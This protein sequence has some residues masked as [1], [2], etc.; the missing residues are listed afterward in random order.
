M[1]TENHFTLKDNF[2]DRKSNFLSKNVYYLLILFFINP[3]FSIG[4]STFLLIKQKGKYDYQ[5]KTLYILISA[6]LG[7]IMTTKVPVSDLLNMKNQFAIAGSMDFFKYIFSFGKEPVFYAFS[8]IFYYI[9]DNNFSLY[10]FFI[11]FT[12]YLLLFSALHKYWSNFVNDYKI[13]LFSVFIIAFFNNY[14]S[15]SGHLVRQV[16]ATSFFLFFFVEKIQSNKNKWLYLIAA[17][18]IHT[19]VIMLFL[20]IFIPSIKKRVSKRIFIGFMLFSIV[21]FFL[22]PLVFR[23]FNRITS[24]IVWLNYGFQRFD[25][26]DGLRDTWY[27]GGGTFFNRLYYLSLLY[28]SFI[29]YFSKIKLLKHHYMINVYWLLVLL[30]EFYVMNDNLFL[31]MRMMVFVFAFIPFIVPYLFCL[32]NTS[33]KQNNLVKLFPTALVLLSIARFFYGLDRSM[34]EYLPMKEILAYPVFMYFF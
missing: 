1:I 32:P 34:Y 10:I 29:A 17:L 6:F 5:F 20:I 27:E 18:F 2:I 26:L 33:G 30:I 23:F 31:Q 4:L 21:M 7:L 13:I 16:W 3:F 12:G 8:Y 11:V 14:F 9:T 25:N 28:I 15:Y 24:G 22:G 19:S